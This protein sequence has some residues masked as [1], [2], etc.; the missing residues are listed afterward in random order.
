LEERK[1]QLEGPPPPPMPDRRER[2]DLGG[3]PMPKT[4]PTPLLR[5]Y[6]P[7]PLRRWEDRR[8]PAIRRHSPEEKISRRSPPEDRPSRR[9]SPLQLKMTPVS[10]PRRHSPPPPKQHKPQKPP[11]D[12]SELSEGEIVSD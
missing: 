4:S 10:P 3:M 7:P 5:P 1:R 6:S 11:I 12:E 9:R 8:K 2:R